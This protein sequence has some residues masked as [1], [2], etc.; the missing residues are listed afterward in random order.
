MVCLPVTSESFA[1]ESSAAERGRLTRYAGLI[2]HLKPG[3]LVE[4]HQD[5]ASLCFSMQALMLRP[6]TSVHLLL[7][8]ICILHEVLMLHRLLL[9]PLHHCAMRGNLHVV[10]ALLDARADVAAKS[11]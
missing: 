5:V 10:Q 8:Y 9:T 3:Q 4:L 2:N 11:K 7:V 1:H 6:W